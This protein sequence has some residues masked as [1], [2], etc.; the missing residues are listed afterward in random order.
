MMELVHNSSTLPH[1]ADTTAHSCL[2]WQLLR[3][4][5]KVFV[6]FVFFIQDAYESITRHLDIHVLSIT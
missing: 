6:I 4:R 2:S 3:R 5:I 1:V